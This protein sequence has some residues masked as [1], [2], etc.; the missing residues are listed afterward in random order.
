V[1]HSFSLFYY[2]EKFRTGV[3][4]LIDFSAIRQNARS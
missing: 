3:R 1:S 2:K 4:N